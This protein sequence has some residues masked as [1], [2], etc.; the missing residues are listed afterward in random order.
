MI[1][2]CLCAVCIDE[3]NSEFVECFLIVGNVVAVF[4]FGIDSCKC[5][6]RC[7]LRCDV[8]VPL[9]EALSFGSR[10]VERFLARYR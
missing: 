6:I 1:F 5:C 2:F 10:R 7:Y 8:A 9:L 3:L 4:I